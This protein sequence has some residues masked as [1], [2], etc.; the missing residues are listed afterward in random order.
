[1]NKTCPQCLVE[2][3]LDAVHFYRSKQTKSGFKPWC[4]VCVN[5]KNQAYDA[6]NPDKRVQRV[7]RSRN[8]S[9]ASKAQHVKRNRAYVERQPLRYRDTRTSRVFGVPK[10]WFTARLEQNQG[11]CEICGTEHQTEAH[12]RFLSIDHC[13]ETGIVRGMICG[14]CNLGL[15][16]F[17]S[18]PELLRA[19]ALYLER[20]GLPNTKLDSSE[21]SAHG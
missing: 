15:G 2:K 3:P 7:Q 16:H 19:A 5:A 18:D 21:S 10:G 12:P 1:M 8:R 17:K 11:C 4:K 14:A 20:A 9:A 6:A 13:H